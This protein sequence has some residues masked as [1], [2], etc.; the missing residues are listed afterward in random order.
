MKRLDYPAPGAALAALFAGPIF[1][2]SWALGTCYARIPAAVPV[3]ASIVI[4]LWAMMITM[5][6]GFILAILP[7]LICAAMMVAL[8]GSATM[9]TPF[10]WGLVGALFPL[11]G[12]L[13]VWG[14]WGPANFALS[15]TGA[16]CALICRR[17]A[18]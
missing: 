13:F 18:V 6:F 17:Y 3:D 7:C 1:V 8:S 5:P 10:M 2:L 14:G 12:T 16:A 11:I 9:R 4:G 15:V